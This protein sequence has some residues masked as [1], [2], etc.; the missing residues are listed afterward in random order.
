MDKIRKEYV[1]IKIVGGYVRE[2]TDYDFIQYKI[3]E[4][5]MK[6]IKKQLIGH[7]Y[8]LLV[9]QLIIPNIYK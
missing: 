1:K 7:L 8:G 4:L 6:K 5:I 3:H 2:V 9:Y